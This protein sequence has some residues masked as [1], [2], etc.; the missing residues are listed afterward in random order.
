MEAVSIQGRGHGQLEQGQAR[1]QELAH[2]PG[3]GSR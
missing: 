1:G 2:R 3:Y